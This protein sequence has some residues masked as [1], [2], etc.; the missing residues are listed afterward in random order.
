[1]LSFLVKHKTRTI[2]GH[3]NSGRASEVHNVD[4]MWIEAEP[5]SQGYNASYLPILYV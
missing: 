1:M 4:L 5:T 3:L 2:K